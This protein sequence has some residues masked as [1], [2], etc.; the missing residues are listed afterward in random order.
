MKIPHLLPLLALAGLAASALPLA[1]VS[2][3]LSITWRESTP[4]PEPRAGYAGGQIGG[5]LVL[6]G[7]TYWE[8]KKGDW[9]KKVF[10]AATHVF[11]PKTETWE[12]LA[13]APVTLGYS[14]VAEV[15]GSLYVMGGVQNGVPGRDVLV[16][17]KN[18]SGYAW[19]KSVPLPDSR[20]FA[21]AVAIGRMIYLIGGTRE[22][23]PFDAKGTC[24]TSKSD[25]KT[26]W[27]LNTMH[28]EKGWT[29]L[30]E[31]PGQ[32]RWAE[33][34]AARGL[35]I[36]L[37]GGHHQALQ[38][39]PVQDFN[40]VLRYDIPTHKWSRVGDMPETAQGGA[41]VM[42]GGK[43]VIVASNHHVTVFDPATGKFTPAADLPEDAALDAVVKIGNQLV[44]SEGENKV[45]G[46]RRRSSWTFIGDLGKK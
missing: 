21:T 29:T 41:N 9:T 8:G 40:E 35:T 39:D 10:T 36:Y 44:G 4:G 31:Y 43:V 30:P 2:A 28:P 27:M 22:F 7:G 6:V 32:A 20:V 5:K 45:E 26:M 16:L 25:T 24:C 18:A 19:S 1:A 3:P 14:A 15:G 37:F 17:S 33:R 38:K 23:E 13:D 42:V 12:K 46:P 34:A 11:D